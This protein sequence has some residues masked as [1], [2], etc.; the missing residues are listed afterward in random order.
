MFEEQPSTFKEKVYR[1]IIGL[2]LFILV[3]TLIIT[4]LP[5]DAEQSF[6]G[7]LTGQSSTKAGNV[8]GRSIPIDYFNAAKRDCYYRYQQYGREMAQNAEILNTCAY[9]TVKEIYIA[10]DMAEAV[11]FQ[12]SETK[13]KRELSKQAREI[14][15]ESSSQAGYGEEDSRSLVEIYQQIYRSVP[16]S[17]RVDT[18][19]AYALY[20]EFLDQKLYPS[21][22]ET[23][24]KEEAKQAK[25]SFRLVAFS[26]VQLLNALEAKIQITD[27]ELLKEYEKEKKD[28]SLS[29]DASGNFVSFE[30]RKPL[31]LSKMKFDRKRKEV[32]T[33]KGRI[34]Q[35]TSLPNALEEI[36]KEVGSS[37]E[38]VAPTSLSDL[39][40]VSTSKGVSYRLAN[41]E[42]F[43]EAL[44]SNP[45][46]KK[47][48]VGP[49]NDN[50]KQVYVEFGDL[51]FGS[52]K[53]S[54]PE[55]SISDFSKDR[56]LLG[57]FVEINQ[58]LAQEY[59]IEKKGI[60]ATE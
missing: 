54:K 31:L 16:M 34:S 29:K 56:Q 18:S 12:V 47:M 13:I 44:A 9:S 38:S 43:W 59:N 25:I 51:S 33:W 14:F 55:P 4:F 24:I 53:T 39:K 36:S 20:P 60:L 32:E 50:D 28:G 10:N 26:E 46:G 40:L 48:V 37:I 27:E 1:T 23:S 6:I 11:G 45:F 35:K 15:K 21:D 57:F 52:S 30:T 41:S 49:L 3:G 8:A 42:K 5:G 19:T 7:A 17:Y 58:S 2:F 22:H